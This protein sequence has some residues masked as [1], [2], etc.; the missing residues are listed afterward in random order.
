[1]KC[2]YNKKELLQSL[3]AMYILDIIMT[4]E[5]NDWSGIINR[6]F[7]ENVLWYIIDNGGGDELTVLFSGKGILI[8]GFDHENE[9]NQF[10]YGDSFNG[11]F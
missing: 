1:M 9:L 7:S 6:G 8:K 11:F 5:E 3:K 2:E 10:A 4:L